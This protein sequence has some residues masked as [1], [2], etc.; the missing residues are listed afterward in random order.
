MTKQQQHQTNEM[1]YLYITQLEKRIE[2]LEKLIPGSIQPQYIHPTPVISSPGP[3]VPN[4]SHVP[5]V[6]NVTH[7]SNIPHVSSVQATA[8]HHVLQ[9]DDFKQN[10]LYMNRRAIS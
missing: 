7:V 1:L 5:S 2:M 9:V 10:R 8:D 3:D 6:P 4:I